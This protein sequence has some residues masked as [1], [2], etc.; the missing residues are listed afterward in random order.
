MRE[1]DMHVVVRVNSTKTPPD[2]Q[3]SYPAIAVMRCQVLLV[4]T[5]WLAAEGGNTG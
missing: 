4:S 1:V 5:Q 2:D 3:T